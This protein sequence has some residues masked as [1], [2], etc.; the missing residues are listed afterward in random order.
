MVDEKLN[1]T[2]H[3]DYIVTKLSKYIHVFYIVGH[4]IPVNEKVQIYHTII[5]PYLIY[6]I[7]VW[8]GSYES[9]LKPVIVLQSIL[10]AIC[11][12]GF[13]SSADPIYQRL[14]ALKKER[15]L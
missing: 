5:Y 8:D 2:S 1:F 6:C 10:Y 14:K 15:N 12:T 3:A 4:F 13:R 9:I 11:N 7:T